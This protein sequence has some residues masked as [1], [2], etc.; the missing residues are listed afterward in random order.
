MDLS[1][2]GKLSELIVN[3][4]SLCIAEQCWSDRDIESISLTNHDRSLP[5][6]DVVHRCLTNQ[7]VNARAH[8]TEAFAARREQRHLLRNKHMSCCGRAGKD[9]NVM[10]KV[11]KAEME[12]FG[13]TREK[14][15]RNEINDLIRVS[16]WQSLVNTD[17]VCNLTTNEVSTVELEVL[18]LGLDFKLENSER[19]MFDAHVAFHKFDS[20]YQGEPGKPDLH[21]DKVKFMSDIH[22]DKS[23]I[24]PLRYNNAMKSLNSNANIKIV[25]SDKGKQ[26]VICHMTTYIALTNG[27]FSNTDLYQPVGVDDI[28]GYDLDTM[29]NDLITEL[30]LLANRAPDRHHK[31]I[32]KSLFPSDN[33]RF[34]EGRINLKTHKEGVTP[35]FIPVRPIISNTN[36]PTSTLA[37]YL[38]ENLTKN[39]GLVSDKHLRSTEDFANFI[40]NCSTKG[41]LLSLDV[42]S[43]FTCIPRMKIIEFLRT[44]SG[45]WGS[46][47]AHSNSQD[48]PVY[49]FDIDSK[50]FCDLVEICLKYNQFTVRGGFFRQIHGLFMGSSI[51]PPLA[52]MYL[53]YFE[54]HL[55]ELSIPDDIKA[56]E[57]KRFVD[58][59][60]IVYEHSEDDFRKFLGM[61]N[62]LDPYIRFTCETATT[63]EEIGLSS[64]VLEALPFLDLM[65]IRHLDR[66]SN[67]LSNKLSIYR[68]PCHSGAYV[69]A[70]SCQPTSIKRAVIRNMF[71]RA[72]RYCDKLF[73]GDEE[74][75]I[76][77]DFGKLGYNKKFIDKAKVSAKKGRNHEVRIREGLEEPK[78]P[79]EKARFLLVSPYHRTAR[80]TK[81]RLGQKG[82]DVAFSN[83][84]SIMNRVTRKTP[85]PTKSGVYVLG[86]ENLDCEEVYIGQSADI[87]LRVSQHDQARRAGNRSYTSVRHSQ[88]LGHHLD[89]ETN[90]AVYKSNCKTRRKIIETALISQCNTIQG[91]KGDTSVKDMDILAPMILKGAPIKW[92]ALSIVQRSSLNPWAVPRKYR[93]FFPIPQEIQTPIL[94]VLLRL[95][96]PVKITG[97]M[98]LAN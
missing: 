76:Y 45:G 27:H 42:E 9:L 69:H 67:T 33:S 49:S 37:S 97:Q 36:S 23:K 41:R 12:K 39:L 93:S 25:L 28:A 29:K 17:K 32:I 75:R 26:V 18:S 58:D 56:T 55:Y 59:C 35:N 57:W 40:K 7:L 43:L 88:L 73:L 31:K 71:L 72:Y 81:H 14:E 77:D 95:I 87:P 65:V 34:P 30:T 66:T 4:L 91:N 13:D 48:P 22:N 89:T 90:L 96:L 63:G 70:F 44:K 94:P 20:K 47:S 60:F 83:R 85:N 2:E 53:E 54:S 61:L 46:D 64:E 21:R 8:K 1:R 52:M 78:P 74:R 5:Y 84:D 82:V 51:S 16:K 80:G 10:F 68:K 62:N 86:C 92:K 3:R 79:R 98:R 6:P 11:T 50:I 38:G 15:M 24:L 19:S